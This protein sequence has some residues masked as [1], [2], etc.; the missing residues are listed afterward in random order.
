MYRALTR[1]VLLFSH[2]FASFF[3]DIYSNSCPLLLHFS[4]RSLSSQGLSLFSTS[5][6]CSGPQ[7]W[8]W[9]GGEMGFYSLWPCHLDLHTEAHV[10]SASNSF[11]SKNRARRAFIRRF[12]WGQHMNTLV[13]L[14]LR[15]FLHLLQELSWPLLQQERPGSAHGR[16][17]N[18][19]QEPEK[20]QDEQWVL[21]PNS[22]EEWFTGLWCT[23]GSTADNIKAGFT[24]K[25][26]N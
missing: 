4:F 7:M 15:R 6:E 23:A 2:S 8:W 3:S 9:A 16:R 17:C 5:W 22:I 26:F 13:V 24:V 25:T 21:Q 20:T 1:S 14:Y 18:R 10:P 12:Y 11:Y 19:K